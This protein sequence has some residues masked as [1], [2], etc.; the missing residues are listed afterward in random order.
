MLHGLILTTHSFDL[1]FQREYTESEF[2]KNVLSREVPWWEE[3]LRMIQENSVTPADTP[4]TICLGD[5]LF[6]VYQIFDDILYIMVGS[7]EYDEIVLCDLIGIVH[8]CIFAVCKKKLSVDSFIEN[9]ATVS[10]VLGNMFLGGHMIFR[11]PPDE[12]LV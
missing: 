4:N 10:T 8:N 6:V 11:S 3:I 12:F 1:L 5:S 7:D 2:W 9:Y